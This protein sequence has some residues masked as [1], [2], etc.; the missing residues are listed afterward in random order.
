VALG[1]ESRMSAAE[2]VAGVFANDPKKTK[3]RNKKKEKRK[4]E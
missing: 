1:D 2:A 4:M 3:K